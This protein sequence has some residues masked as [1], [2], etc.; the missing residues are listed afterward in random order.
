MIHTYQQQSCIFIILHL[1][2]GKRRG[3]QAAQLARDW[4]PL[5]FCKHFSTCHPHVLVFNW[6]T[7]LIFVYEHDLCMFMP[8]SCPCVIELIHHGGLA[9]AGRF[10]SLLVASPLGLSLSHRPPPTIPP[11]DR[12]AMQ[13]RT[14]ALL[15][16][17]ALV[18][19]VATQQV[20]AKQDM[21]TESDYQSFVSTTH[22]HTR[23]GEGHGASGRL[24]IARRPA[25]QPR[26]MRH[27][28][29]QH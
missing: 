3:A 27:A 6:L 13:I 1:L 29:T 23:R 20:D 16:L 10:V 19:V 5:F 9:V 12:S 24:P 15:A 7:N 17:V 25:P 14:F 26:A 4:L 2:R 11:T 8:Y 21:L 28:D 22:T 18:A